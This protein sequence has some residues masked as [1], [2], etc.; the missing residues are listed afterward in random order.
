MVL[1]APHYLNDGSDDGLLYVLKSGPDWRLMNLPKAS[2]RG[3]LTSGAQPA[4]RRTAAC[5][6][7]QTPACRGGANGRKH[8]RQPLAHPPARPSARP[9]WPTPAGMQLRVLGTVPLLGRNSIPTIEVSQLEVITN[10]GSDRYLA[11]ARAP[12]PPPV[13]GMRAGSSTGGHMFACGPVCAR[14]RACMREHKRVPLY[15]LRGAHFKWDPLPC[16]YDACPCAWKGLL[17]GR[18]ER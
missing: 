3:S 17:S 12:P 7:V 15:P 10:P 18:S 8:P 9:S 1:V 14:V 2:R 11:Q 16:S 4:L 6:A 13:A 5:H